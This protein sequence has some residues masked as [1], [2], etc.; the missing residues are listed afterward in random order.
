[1][2]HMHCSYDPYLF[3]YT[4]PGFMYP[5]TQTKSVQDANALTLTQGDLD[6]D[7]SG[8]LTR[9]EVA[10]VPLEVLPP[11]V[12]ENVSVDSMEDGSRAKFDGN[13]H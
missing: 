1:M 12:L 2:S 6:M 11:K 7:G 10:N 4:L 13:G 3:S 8:S 5:C 9:D